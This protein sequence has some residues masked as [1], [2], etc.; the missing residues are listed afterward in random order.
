MRRIL[1]LDEFEEFMTDELPRILLDYVERMATLEKPQAVEFWLDDFGWEKEIVEVWPIWTW[2]GIGHATVNYL[3]DRRGLI[4]RTS[5]SG[6]RKWSLE[7]F[8]RRF[9]ASNE[10]DEEHPFDLQDTTAKTVDIAAQESGARG[11]EDTLTATL[12]CTLRS[13]GHHRG[14]MD[15]VASFGFSLGDPRDCPWSQSAT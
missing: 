3:V 6:K 12:S 9:T 11:T 7:E 1:K 4:Y 15:T 10:I 2:E 5:D 13:S 14:W 8:A